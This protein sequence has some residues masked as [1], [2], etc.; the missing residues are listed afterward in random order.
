[1]SVNEETRTRYFKEVGIVLRQQGF[2]ISP[3]Q[4]DTLEVFRDDHPICKVTESGGIRYNADI[5]HDPELERL[6]DQVYQ[7][8]ATTAEYMKLLEAAPPLQVESLEGRFKVLADFNGTVFAAQPSDYGTQF[9]TWDWDFDRN[10]LSHGH[11]FGNNYT[12]CK[13]DFAVRAGLVDQ[14]RLFAEEQLIEVYRCCADTL[15]AGYDL[16]DGQR[17]CIKGIQEQVE[18]SIPDITEW[19]QAY[20]KQVLEQEQQTQEQSMK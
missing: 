17:T 18:I 5:M 8:S 3:C 6:K 19:I 2:H 1:M 4:A 10:G 9:V 20:D 13:E 7:I 16:T 11:Y 15:D 14:H 12:G